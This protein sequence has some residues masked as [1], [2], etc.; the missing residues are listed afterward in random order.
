M[1]GGRR[2]R[3]VNWDMEDTISQGSKTYVTLGIICLLSLDNETLLV[4]QTTAFI[5]ALV[6]ANLL[7]VRMA[8]QVSSKQGATK[9]WTRMTC[10]L[11]NTEPSSR[12]FAVE[13]YSHRNHVNESRDVELNSIE[14]WHFWLVWG[15]TLMIYRH[16]AGNTEEIWNIILIY[17][18]S[19]L[20]EHGKTN[21]C[22]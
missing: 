19:I 13:D 21:R 15:E 20:L 16:T 22:S 9:W 17:V 11:G 8:A 1:L 7:I 12:L 14:N 6:G 18:T 3:T 10:A 2:I 5:T 4:C